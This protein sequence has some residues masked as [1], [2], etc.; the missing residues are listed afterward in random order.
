M[1]IFF[2]G[3]NS[4]ALRQQ[5]SQMV[6]AYLAKAGSDYGLERLDGVTLK[7]QELRGALQATPFLATSRLV[8]VEGLAANKATAEKLADLMKIVPPTTVAVFVER[9][10]DQ[11]TV[12]FKTLR[13]ADKVMKFEALEGPR[14]LGWVRAEIERL[15]GVAEPAAI[16]ELVELAGED[17]WRLAGEINKLVNYDRQVTVA[18]VRELVARSV[19]RS[20]FDLVEAMAAGRVEAALTAYRALLDHKESEMYVLTMIQWQLRN[21]L[22]AKMAPAGM[23]PADLAK[24]AGMSPFVAGKMMTAQGGMN[25]RLLAAAYRAAAECEFDIKTGRLKAEMAVEQ[26]IY[27]ASSRFRRLAA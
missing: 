17:Q 21:L 1:T 20:I 26:L 10:V 27:K 2:Y 24:A 7:A 8:I 14:L 12:A 22:L 15:G 18:A 6:R 16:R 3:P 4:Y 19:E 9:E 23:S 11:R 25:E 13:T 5:L